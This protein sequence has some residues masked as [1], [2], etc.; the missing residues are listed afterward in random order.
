MDLRRIGA[1]LAAVAVL[2]G[3]LPASSA[4]AV[5]S[6]GR[7]FAD[8][9]SW[10]SIFSGDAVWDHPREHVARMHG[11]GVHTLFLQTASSTSP[12]GSQ[13]YRPT[14]VARFLHAAHARGMRVVAWY[15]PPLRDV[16]REY[17]RAM[18]AVDFR[19]PGGQR[20]DA[21]ALDIEPSGTT[22][23]GALRNDNLRRLSN[24]LRTAV[25]P[26]Y[27]LGAII[28]SPIGLSLSPKFWPDFPYATLGRFYDV[29]LPMSYSTYRV[30]GATATYD[31]TMGNIAFLRSVLGPTVSLHVI[32]G[33]AGASG[34][35]ETR[36]FVQACNNARVTGASMWHY[37]AYGDE[38]WQEMAALGL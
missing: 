2:L 33:N 5:T 21:F 31:Y 17:R 15:L 28:P 26:T 3:L 20:F 6:V 37:T 10:V 35:L 34:R 22:P 9:G 30:K 12:V 4:T 1:V 18:S 19:T 25:G 23:S 38:D 29:V 14:Q 8:A 7:P 24:R 32:G 11:A 13:V 36:A 27:K 16:G